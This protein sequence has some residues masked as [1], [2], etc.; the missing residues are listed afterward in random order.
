MTSATA[1]LDEYLEH[2]NRRSGDWPDWWPDQ[3]TLNGWTDRSAEKE[4][5]LYDGLAELL[6]RRY[7][8]GDLSFEFCDWVANNVWHLMITRDGSTRVFSDTLHELYE[9][10]DAGEWS[11]FG[12]SSDPV[13]DYTNPAIAVIVARLSMQE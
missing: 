13:T 4:L 11:H 10:F 2:W 9:A 1:V 5:E 12:K 7:H 8:A 3:T 6:A